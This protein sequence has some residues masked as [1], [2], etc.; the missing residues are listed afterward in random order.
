MK[1]AAAGR[2]CYP[3]SMELGGSFTRAAA[4]ALVALL[5]PA[6]GCAYSNYQSARMLPTGG[7]SVG[8]AISQYGIQGGDVSGDEEAVEVM[9]SHGISDKVELGGK[10]AW[11]L[12]EDADSFNF[13]FVPKLSLI[14]DQ[15]ALTV[16]AGL[17]LVTGDASDGDDTAWLLMPT[18]V[19]SQVLSEY[20]ELDLAAKP[21]I[22]FEND[23]GDSDVAFAANVGVRVTPPGQRWGLHPEIGIMWDDDMGDE[24]DYY[25]QLG[26]AFV[27]ELGPAR[28][29]AP[30]AAAPPAQ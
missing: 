13:L 7:T 15:L 2:L 16:P 30:A 12:I 14:P 17:I 24:G 28:A 22:G 25:L 20:F 1:V 4:V 8:A 27:Y 19:F 5:V 9:A 26:L 18:V 10:L 21:V 3:R 23:F 29:S 11:F 6:A